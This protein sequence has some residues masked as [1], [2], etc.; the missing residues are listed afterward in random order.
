MK[1][2]L[3]IG[4]VLLASIANSGFGE[5]LKVQHGSSLMAKKKVMVDLSRKGA[6]DQ[7]EAKAKPDLVGIELGSESEK[8]SDT[9]KESKQVS[10]HGKALTTKNA[11]AQMLAN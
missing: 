1:N 10:R 4:L 7:S 6:F 3:V 9:T 5:E 11:T 2:K 8:L